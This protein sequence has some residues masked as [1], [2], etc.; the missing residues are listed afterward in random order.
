M[1]IKNIEKN[2]ND[3]QGIQSHQI[4]DVTIFD[5]KMHIWIYPIRLNFSSLGW[6]DVSR[7]IYIW[8]DAMSAEI[9]S[10]ASVTLTIQMDQWAKGALT[11]CV[12]GKK[13][14][15]IN[16]L[17]SFY[18]IRPLEIRA[19]LTNIRDVLQIKL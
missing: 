7:I 17:S 18:G 12:D 11:K 5:M 19:S 15:H 6:Y 14:E 2:K 4:I 3:I 8:Y 10:T 13:C 1:E 16:A 9:L